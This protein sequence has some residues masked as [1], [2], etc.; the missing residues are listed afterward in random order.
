MSYRGPAFCDDP[1]FWDELP[2]M[3]A[4][5][6]RT[7]SGIKVPTQAARA[8]REA[9]CR[10][11]DFYHAIKRLGLSQ[12]EAAL[13][14]GASASQRVSEWRSG[15]RKVPRYIQMHLRTLLGIGPTDPWPTLER[16][17]QMWLPSKLR[18]IGL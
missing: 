7:S 15:R 12:R 1:P 17:H 16:R 8:A 2:R 4:G 6:P 9:P 3:K 18:G 13:V 11:I 10:P 5:F 14:L